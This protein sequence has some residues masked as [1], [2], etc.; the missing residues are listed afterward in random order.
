MKL[1]N[2]RLLTT[3]VAIGIFICTLIVGVVQ[4][5]FLINKILIDQE[6]EQFISYSVFA[7]YNGQNHIGMDINQVKSIMKLLPGDIDATFE[8][9]L[10]KNAE[11]RY[12][13]EMISSKIVTTDKNYLN[14]NTMK[15]LKGR[16]FDDKDNQSSEKVCVIH[17]NMYNLLGKKD[18]MTL[19]IGGEDFKVIGVVSG[20][21]IGVS[22]IS[23]SSAYTEDEII[24]MPINT[25]FKYFEEIT[26][27][28]SG[29]IDQILIRASRKYTKEL[30]EKTISPYVS[31]ISMAQSMKIAEA[32]EN[33]R[34]A[35]E[36]TLNV[37][38]K[39][40]LIAS[41]VLLLAGLNIVQIT[42]A[43]L[44]D[45]K[46]EIG[47]KMALGARRIDITKEVASDVILCT[48]KGGY[49]GVALYALMFFV[50]NKFIRDYRALQ[51]VISPMLRQ[52]MDYF[53]LTFNVETVII[54]I[55]LSLVLGILSA[56]IPA[57]KSA[58]I[59]PIEVLRKE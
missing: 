26:P 31:E 38:G 45:I 32:G 36:N 41:L 34:L 30:L 44:Y 10:T 22:F 18:D 25:Y 57:I 59:D 52:Y 16:Y 55:L 43:N 23:R 4:V 1:I 33:E 15:L 21:S 2:R 46:K 54:G 27:E 29:S 53:R 7:S 3:G 20:G 28:H 19:N 12:N 49:I 56:V 50:A 42:T 8:S 39:I 47:L 14:V 13:N 37:V 9:V 48:L 51:E 11:T 6:K 24:F 5:R 35:L 40:L 17:E 58:S